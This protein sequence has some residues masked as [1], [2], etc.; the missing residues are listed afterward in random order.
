MKLRMASG[1]AALAVAAPICADELQ[2]ANSL[3]CSAVEATVCD[4]DGECA[5]GP[6]WDWNIP[7]FIEIDLKKGVIATTKA[8]GEDRT[9][10]I[11]NQERSD[12]RIILQGFE[13]GRAFSFV[14]NEKSGIASVA[15]ATN[16]LTISVF[17]ACTPLVRR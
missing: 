8:S 10:P 7:Q 11:R 16:E 9:T 15:I 6:S 12:G 13:M 1:V 5:S 14:I 4:A 17:A 2:G 3:L